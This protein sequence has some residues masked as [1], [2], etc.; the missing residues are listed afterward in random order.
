M[1]DAGIIR[2]RAQ[3]RRDHRATR[4]PRREHADEGLDRAA[5]VV[6]ARADARRAAHARRAC[7]RTTPES[8]AMSKALEAR[9]FRFVGPTTMYA[10]MQSTGIV[11]DH[12]AGCFRRCVTLSGARRDVG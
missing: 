4:A 6:R 10:L 11:D 8:V 3:D 7:P 12:V 9:G 2:N 5:L 1:A